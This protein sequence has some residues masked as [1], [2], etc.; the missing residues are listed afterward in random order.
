MRGKLQK[1]S[2]IVSKVAR[3][4]SEKWLK[5]F[6]VKVKIHAA[7][8]SKKQARQEKNESLKN[9]LSQATKVSNGI[10]SENLDESVVIDVDQSSY[11]RVAQ[12]Q[13]IEKQE[14]RFN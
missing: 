10:R 12:E 2:L 3:K 11:K 1:Q 14:H 7:N 8:S 13:P 5:D 9:I 6:F 4:V